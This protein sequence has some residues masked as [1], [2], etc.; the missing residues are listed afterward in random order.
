MLKRIGHCFKSSSDNKI[1]QNLI[2]GNILIG[3]A[4]F[5]ELLLQN[6]KVLG[7]FRFN[8]NQH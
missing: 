1:S 8:T 6:R 7:I 5:F 2:V 4:R 3:P